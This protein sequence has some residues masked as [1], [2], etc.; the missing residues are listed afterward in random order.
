MLYMHIG[1]FDLGENPGIYLHLKKK[2][3]CDLLNFGNAM[4]VSISWLILRLQHS[5]LFYRVR[6]RKQLRHFHALRQ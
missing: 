2:Y 4:I 3:I 5:N 6:S 1:W